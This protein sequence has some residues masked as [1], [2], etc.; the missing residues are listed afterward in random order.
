[1]E[2]PDEYNEAI[3]DNRPED[4]S[5]WIVYGDSW[6]GGIELSILSKYF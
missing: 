5:E 6:G 1:M 3:L 4:Y 2:H